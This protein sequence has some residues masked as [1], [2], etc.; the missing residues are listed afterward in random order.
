MKPLATLKAMIHADMVRRYPEIPERLL[1]NKPIKATKANELTRAVIKFIQLK[2]GQA[3]RISVTGRRVD[4]RKTYTD[5][6]GQQRQI[7][8][9]RWIKSSMQKGS[10]DISATIA[11]QSVKIEIKVG[12]D[13][14]RPEQEIYQ[15]QVE[16]A[17]GIYLM[18]HTFDEFYQW[19]T[20]KYPEK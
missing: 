8:S 6:L 10:A 16:K 9:V 17:G 14:I 4:M 3:E 2:G 13:R 1:P 19:Y 12:R 7:G 15:Q 18:I 20:S 5:V 11:G